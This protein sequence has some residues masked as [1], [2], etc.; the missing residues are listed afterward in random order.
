MFGYIQILKPEMKIGEYEIYQGIYCSLCRALGKRYGIFSRFFLNY[1]MTFAAV[2][3]LALREEEPEYKAMRCSFNPLIRR[4]WSV[5]AATLEPL[6]DLHV[7]LSYHKAED[8]IHDSKGFKKIGAKILHRW[9]RRSYRQASARF[10][11]TSSG[12][13]TAMD[14]QWK[15]EE[16]KSDSFDLACEPTAIM[17]SLILSE[18][19]SSESD[20]RILRRMGYCLGRW[21]YLMDAVDDYEEDIQTENYNVMT[22]FNQ[23]KQAV[24]SQAEASMNA[25]LGETVRAYDLL[26]LRRYRGILDNILKGGLPYRQNEILSKHLSLTEAEKLSVEKEETESM[27]TEAKIESERGKSRE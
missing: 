22:V 8:T 6:A 4:E 16:K 20:K 17:L 18:L 5:D 26:S 21:I 13:Q 12:I 19:S 2:L 14:Q 9:L 7:L 25:S 3:Y 1:D 10:P 11:E 23:T 24:F 27:K 15:V